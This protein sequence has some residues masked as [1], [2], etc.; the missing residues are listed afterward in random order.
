[1]VW[2][3]DICAVLPSL[4]DIW[5]LPGLAIMNEVAMKLHVQMFCVAVSFIFLGEMSRRVAAR[6]Y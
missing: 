2:S 1:M 4:K 3:D 5:D 6:S